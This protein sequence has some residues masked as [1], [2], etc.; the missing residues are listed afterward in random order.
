MSKQIKVTINN[1]ECYCDNEVFEYILKI[2][3]KMEELEYN[4]DK[5]IEYIEEHKRNVYSDFGE[6]IVFGEME[7]IKE[8]LK[9]LKGEDNDENK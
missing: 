1:K 2:S 4:R 5:A 7:G 3:N 9:I 6:D 8:L